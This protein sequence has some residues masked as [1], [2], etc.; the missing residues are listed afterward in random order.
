[1]SFLTDGSTQPFIP[2][3]NVGFNRQTWN[4]GQ[5]LG[6]A[7]RNMYRRYRPSAAPTDNTTNRISNRA[8]AQRVLRRAQ[9]AARRKPRTTNRIMFGAQVPT[10]GGESKSNYTSSTPNFHNSLTKYL[11]AFTVNRNRATTATATQGVQTLLLISDSFTAT[12]VN[13][14]FVMLAETSAGFNAAKVFI[15]S[16]YSQSMM[17]NASNTNMHATIFDC[18]ATVDGFT[19]VNPDPVTALTLGGIDAQ[20]GV[21]TDIFIPGTMPWNNPRYKASYRTLQQTSIILSPGQ[22]HVH[23]VK[24]SPNRLFNKERITTNGVGPIGGLTHYS[25]VIFHGTPVHDAATELSIGLSPVKLDVVQLETTQYKQV[26]TPHAFSSITSSIPTN[27]LAPEQWVE[28]T[29]TDTA[30]AT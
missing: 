8:T 25:F 2:F 3:G 14:V 17:T 28:D 12:D 27:I 21:A 29:P 4:R 18:V 9:Q 10:S 20:G 7:L 23:R 30:A 19:T 11:G 5:S 15:Q 1:M 22:V 13:Q 26:A 24:L 16:T 6:R